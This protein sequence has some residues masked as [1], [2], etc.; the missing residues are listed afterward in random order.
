M[1]AVTSTSRFFCS[2]PLSWLKL[3]FSASINHTGLYSHSY[4]HTYTKYPNRHSLFPPAL[5]CDKTRTC[6]L[7]S[8]GSLECVRLTCA[9]WANCSKGGASAACCCLLV[10]FPF[11]FLF[12]FL[13]CRCVGAPR[14]GF[15]ARGFPCDSI[16][17]R[18]QHRQTDPNRRRCAIATLL[19]T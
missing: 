5:P 3:R 2:F 17:A 18:F 1:R 16:P 11:S 10:F 6:T 12:F 14:P 13:C 8:S 7:F 19:G 9:V 15:S 4:I